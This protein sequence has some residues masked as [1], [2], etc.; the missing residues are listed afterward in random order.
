MIRGTP[1]LFMPCSSLGLNN[2]PFAATLASVNEDDSVNLSVIDAAGNQFAQPNVLLLDEGQPAPIDDVA[3]AYHI[4]DTPSS[5][6]PPPAEEV[7]PVVATGDA[8]AKAAPKA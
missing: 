2:G 1:L 4:N 7:P 3:Y 5:I 6:E 8:S